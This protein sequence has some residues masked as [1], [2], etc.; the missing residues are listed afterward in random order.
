MEACVNVLTVEGALVLLLICI[1]LAV[2]LGAVR[3]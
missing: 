1:A 3:R 2:V